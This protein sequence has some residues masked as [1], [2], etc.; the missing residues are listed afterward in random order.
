[1]R[2]SLSWTF[3]AGVRTWVAVAVTT[4]VAPGLLLFQALPVSATTQSVALFQGAPDTPDQ[5]TG[6]AAGLASLVDSAATATA[7]KVKP[8]KGSERD[9]RQ[10]KGALPIEERSIGDAA[11]A[12]DKAGSSAAA[13]RKAQ[14]TNATASVMLA[15]SDGWCDDY[16]TWSSTASYSYQNVVDYSTDLWQ[17][18]GFSAPVGTPPPLATH[19]WFKVGTCSFHQNPTANVVYPYDGMLMESRTPTLRGE[20]RSNDTSSVTLMGFTFKVCENAAMTTGCTTSAVV[21]NYW[22]GAWKVPAGKL[23]WS[24]Q[25]WWNVTVTDT[26][27][28]L[29]TTSSVRTFTTG[30]RQP[31]IGSQLAAR[32]STARSSTSCRATTPPRPRTCRWPRPG[33][34]CR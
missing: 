29:K 31:V 20:G 13:A 16:P 8:P 17:I 24:K 1:M 6:S 5:M 25:Y 27:N 32:G 22:S 14:S 26:S 18:I 19:S 34:R 7:V 12:A 28:G 9:P 11:E 30:V 21:N 2:R 23:A 15:A 3:S 4:V 33:R 10:R